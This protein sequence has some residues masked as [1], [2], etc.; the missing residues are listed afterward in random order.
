MANT[1]ITKR[2]VLFTLTLRLVDCAYTTLQQGATT[3]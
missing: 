1:N 2:S 3:L